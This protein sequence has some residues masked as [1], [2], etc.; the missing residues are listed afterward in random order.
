MLTSRIIGDIRP[1]FS[2][3]DPLNGSNTVGIPDFSL[4]TGIYNC[5]EK[6]KRNWPET[7]E[8]KNEGVIGGRGRGVSR[9]SSIHDIV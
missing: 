2:I 9:Y 8:S 4:Q 6:W 7:L 3:P 5:E 1:E